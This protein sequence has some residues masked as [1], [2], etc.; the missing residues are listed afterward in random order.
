[1]MDNQGTDGRLAGQEVTVTLTHSVWMELV[2]FLG[3]NWDRLSESAEYTAE[4]I[5][6]ACVAVE[7]NEAAKDLEKRDFMLGKRDTPIGD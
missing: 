4:Q 3:A 7:H 2:D 5:E 1:M 6:A